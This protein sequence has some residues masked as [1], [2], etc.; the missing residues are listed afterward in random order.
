MFRKI[1]IVR[2]MDNNSL[3]NF[4]LRWSAKCQK[5]N[6]SKNN[7]E[8]LRYAGV[9]SGNL[10]RGLFSKDRAS[11]YKTVMVPVNGSEWLVDI[12]HVQYE[13]LTKLIRS[14]L[15]DV[16]PSS[17]KQYW[18]FPKAYV[19]CDLMDEMGRSSIA[20]EL[21]ELEMSLYAHGVNQSRARYQQSI[22]SGFMLGNIGQRVR[23]SGL[24]IVGNSQLVSLFEDQISLSDWLVRPKASCIIVMGKEAGDQELYQLKETV[25]HMMETGQCDMV[26]VIQKASHDLYAASW[27]YKLYSEWKNYIFSKQA[28]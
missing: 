14:V 16:S 13:S 27:F 2:L 24:K 11:G 3:L 19:E 26:E 8:L 5:K 28:M 7:I 22:V 6:Q 4:N 10:A 1:T 9:F 21:D 12:S 15:P 20:N 25:L 18:Y 17:S 23:K